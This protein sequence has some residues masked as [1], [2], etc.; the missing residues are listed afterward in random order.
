[1]GTRQIKFRF[2]S[3]VFTPRSWCQ[4]GSNYR[5][6]SLLCC[7]ALSHG[8]WWGLSQAWRYFGWVTLCMGYTRCF[9]DHLS[10][11]WVRRLI[12]GTR[13]Q[14]SFPSAP[15]C[16]WIPACTEKRHSVHVSFICYKTLR[17]PAH[18]FCLKCGTA[19][20][21]KA[22]HWVL[23]N[24]GTKEEGIRSSARGIWVKGGKL[25]ISFL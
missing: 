22:L 11:E 8:S 5:R 21:C 16:Q 19:C 7:R 23:N 3:V 12:R 25:G 13:E 15:F 18:V 20:T 14:P 2:T 9:R 10:P 24:L 17:V 4:P 6:T 1:M